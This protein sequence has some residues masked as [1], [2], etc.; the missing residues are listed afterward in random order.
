[1]LMCT[2]KLYR[3]SLVVT[4][5]DGWLNN[6]SVAAHMIWRHYHVSINWAHFGVSPNSEVVFSHMYSRL[7]HVQNWN[8]WVWPV[9]YFPYLRRRGNS[10]TEVHKLICI[11]L[12]IYIILSTIWYY[13]PKHWKILLLRSE[14]YQV[15]V[16]S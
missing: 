11:P 12:F 4:C 16:F 6:Y 7:V 3:T 8:R 1:M 13:P 10:N 2:S 5:W 14:F 15:L 9:I